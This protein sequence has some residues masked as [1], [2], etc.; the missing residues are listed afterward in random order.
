MLINLLLV[1]FWHTIGIGQ[2]KL[3]LKPSKFLGEIYFF[4]ITFHFVFDSSLSQGGV[5][6]QISNGSLASW[7]FCSHNPQTHNSALSLVRSWTIV[8]DGLDAIFTVKDLVI[9]WQLFAV[10]SSTT[11]PW[12]WDFP[13]SWDYHHGGNMSGIPVSPKGL[14]WD[15]HVLCCS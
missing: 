11:P 6:V 3:R 2:Y 15:V 5:A 7:V 1:W 13:D 4:L 8:M 9:R 12:P 14:Q 10:A